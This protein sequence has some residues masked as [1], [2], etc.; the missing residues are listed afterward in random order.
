[1]LYI[2]V[3]NTLVFFRKGGHREVLVS[4]SVPNQILLG[5]V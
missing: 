1:M 5:T 4:A 2:R 3:K